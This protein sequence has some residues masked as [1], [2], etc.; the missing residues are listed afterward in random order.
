M[1]PRAPVEAPGI[2]AA[3]IAPPP[4]TPA[5]ALPQVPDVAQE[6]GG[7]EGGGQQRA[8][9]QGAGQEGGT[10]AGGGQ[11]PDDTAPMSLTTEPQL[12]DGRWSWTRALAVVVVAEAA[13]LWLAASLGLWR[14]RL[15]L[16]QAVGHGVRNARLLRPAVALLRRVPRLRSRM[17]DRAALVGR[18]IRSR[19]E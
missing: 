14:R 17:A 13:V 15:L 16:G 2:P 19:G 1:N 7:Q 11:E 3:P 9:H 12:P 6:G 4:A 5:L 10:Q 8:G 18:R